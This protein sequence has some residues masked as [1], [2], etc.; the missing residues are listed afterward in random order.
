MKVKPIPQLALLGALTFVLAACQPPMAPAPTAAPKAAAPPTAAPA[1]PQTAAPAAKSEPAAAKPAESAASAS[2]QAIKAA[3]DKYYEAAKKEGRII[4]YGNSLTPELI[5]ATKAGFA[6]RFPGVEIMG[7]EMAGREVREKIIAEQASKNYVADIAFTGYTTQR[8]LTEA[9]MFEPYESPQLP[10]L[11]PQFVVP[12][13][14]VNPRTASLISITINTNLVPPDQEPKVWADVLNPKWKGKLAVLDPRG[15]GEGGTIIAGMELVYGYQWLEKLKEQD[16]FFSKSTG[17][18]WA[19]LARGEYAMYL[20]ARHIDAIVNRKA[21]AP[22]KFIKPSDGVGWTYASMGNIK[23]QPHPNAARLF[24]EWTLSDEGQTI[25]GQ[26]GFVAVRQGV[27][28]AEPEASMEGVTLL[29]RDMT[30][31]ANEKLGDDAARTK[32]WDALF[33]N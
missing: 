29:P 6:K 16:V 13:G 27:K 21:G 4:I 7:T 12:G 32:R 23:N 1:K 33:F 3:G 26:D 22:V 5:D 11:F 9:G 19:G 28:S 10:H 30:P 14:V 20:T 25:L 2:E 15:S 18:I 24:M 8:D 17:P 31:E